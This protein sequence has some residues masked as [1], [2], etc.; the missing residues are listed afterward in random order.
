[1]ADNENEIIQE[2]DADDG[3]ASQPTI[4]GRQSFRQVRRELTEE[5]LSSPAAQ[6][7][8]L[9]EL[10]RLENENSELKGISVRFHEVDKKA[11][12]LSEKLKRHTALDILSSAALAAGSLALGYAPKVWAE[13]NATGPIF[14]VI[15]IVMIAGGIWSKAVR[16]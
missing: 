11:S 15:G 1:M 4:K 13:D 12:I 3:V 7:L 9:D 8:I 16:A 5:E 2:P 6:R 10:D 14:L